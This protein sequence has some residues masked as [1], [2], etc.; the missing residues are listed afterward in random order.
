MTEREE[1]VLYLQ[2]LKKWLC[3]DWQRLLPKDSIAY[4]AS[5]REEH[6]YDVAIN[7]LSVPEIEKNTDLISREEAFVAIRNL[8]PDMPTI[9]IFGSW[10]KWKEDN[11]QYLECERIISKLP[12]I[13][14]ERRQGEWISVSE[15]L[16]NLDDYT[17]SEVWQKKV[18]ITGYLSFDD[19]KDPFVSE[20][21]ATDV[22]CNCVNHIV[23]TAWMPLPKPYRVESEE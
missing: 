13:T 11:K 19:K 1:A 16:P 7:A 10:D 17:G 6:Y 4:V 12:S 9:N 21:F 15:R 5:K 23:V 14:P 2:Q 20:A 8:Y 18:L 22:T 3:E